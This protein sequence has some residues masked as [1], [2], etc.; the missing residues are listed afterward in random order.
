MEP[1]LPFSCNAARFHAAGTRYRPRLQYK[2]R[3]GRTYSLRYGHQPVKRH[4][5]AKQDVWRGCPGHGRLR[6]AMTSVCLLAESELFRDR[7]GCALNH[8]RD[9]PGVRHED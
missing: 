2:H 8:I 7:T 9:F 3:Q 1:G 6:S 4:A 5:P